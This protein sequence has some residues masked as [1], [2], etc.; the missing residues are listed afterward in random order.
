MGIVIK[1]SAGKPAR[2]IRPALTVL[3]VVGAA[4]AAAGQ[5]LELPRQPHSLTLS[6]PLAPAVRPAT[7]RIM[8][9]PPAAFAPSAQR[10]LPSA[11][12]RIP[13]PDLDPAPTPA[14]PEPAALAMVKPERM[15]LSAAPVKIVQPRPISE[16]EATAK[17][18]DARGK[19]VATYSATVKEIAASRKPAP[20]AMV[21]AG[22]RAAATR[23]AGTGDFTPS[24]TSRL[25]SVQSPARAMVGSLP[26]QPEAIPMIEPERVAMADTGERKSRSI[27]SVSLQ[28][29]AK[30]NGTP[31]GRV[32]LLIR[33]SENISVQL[34]DILPIL[35]SAVEPAIYER[36][37]ALQGQN[38]VT[39]ND[40][41]AAGLSVRFDAH[42]HLLLGKR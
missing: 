26:M 35:E 29:S 34:G 6:Q 37:S 21:D 42:D 11:T 8:L 9:P 23:M 33:D 7:V 30:V 31:A 20:I 17:L 39:L 3:L 5:P 12:V 4:V 38:Y 40:L 36:I 18:A 27:A 19:D 22:T 25:A 14:A 13:L 32:S 15:P 1:R 16:A 24:D 41:R 10:H 28:V 2:P